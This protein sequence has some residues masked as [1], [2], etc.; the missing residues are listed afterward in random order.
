M[1]QRIRRITFAK[2]LEEK[3]AEIA[4]LRGDYA[5]LARFV[6]RLSGCTGDS[7]SIE[8]KADGDGTVVSGH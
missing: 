3:D 6:E 1:R 2:L 4:R 5:V 7:R 8:E